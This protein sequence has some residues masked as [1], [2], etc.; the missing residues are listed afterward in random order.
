MQIMTKDGWR[1]LTSFKAYWAAKR[2]RIADA[3]AK[4]EEVKLLP[5]NTDEQRSWK[6]AMLNA[7]YREVF[8]AHDALHN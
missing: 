5:S 2:Q 6:H 7:A 3:T 8:A 4:L 1:P